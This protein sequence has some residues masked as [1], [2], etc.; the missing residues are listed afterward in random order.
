[1]SSE[2]SKDIEIDRQMQNNWKMIFMMAIMSQVH[3]QMAWTIGKTVEKGNN[4]EAQPNLQT[5]WRRAI[6]LR[7]DF[8]FALH[9]VCLFV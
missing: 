1:M 5:P 4:A 6:T 7:E 9:R 3:K 2:R 8:I